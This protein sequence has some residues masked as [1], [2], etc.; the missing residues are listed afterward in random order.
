[1]STCQSQQCGQSGRKPH[2]HEM[3][4]DVLLEEQLQHIRH[5]L[6]VMSGKGGVGKT[7]VAVYPAC[8]GS[9][10]GS[11]WMPRDI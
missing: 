10:A 9:A 4:D 3:E 5:K 11:R 1:M 6:L 7:S 8:W 2:R